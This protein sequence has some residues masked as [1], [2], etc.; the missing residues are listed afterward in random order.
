[1]SATCGSCAAPIVWAKTA[2]GSLMPLD[3][4]PV[5]DGNVA[6]YRDASGDVRARVLKAGEEPQPHER[7]G[8][9]HFATCASADQHRKRKAARHG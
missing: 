5:P 3:A 2:T 1:M 6:A 8:V 7:R 9:S 4:Q